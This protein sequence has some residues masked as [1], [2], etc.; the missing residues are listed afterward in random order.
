MGC[1]KTSHS[2]VYPTAVAVDCI[3][4]IDDRLLSTA[5]LLDKN[6]FGKEQIFLGGS[7]FAFRENALGFMHLKGE[8]K[9]LAVS[10][11]GA[12]GRG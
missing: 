6:F 11:Y 10:R 8:Y 5:A 4:Y 7:G 12:R 9:P 1:G 2:R 3:G